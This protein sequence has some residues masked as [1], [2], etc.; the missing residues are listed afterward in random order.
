MDVPMAPISVELSD[1]CR[2]QV[3]VTAFSFDVAD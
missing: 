1:A 3:T 2:V